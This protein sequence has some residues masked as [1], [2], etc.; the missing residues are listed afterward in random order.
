M[1]KILSYMAPERYNI[2][3]EKKEK[4]IKLLIRL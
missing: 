1:V 3:L 2:S 4:E